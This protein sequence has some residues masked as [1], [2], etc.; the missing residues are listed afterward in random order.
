MSE[1]YLLVS[2][3][4]IYKQRHWFPVIN[5]TQSRNSQRALPQWRR[6][7]SEIWPASDTQWQHLRSGMIQ[8]P[9]SERI[10][11]VLNLTFHV[12]NLRILRCYR[13]LVPEKESKLEYMRNTQSFVFWRSQVR[14]SA[15]RQVILTFICLPK[16][17]RVNTVMVPQ[18][19]PRPHLPHFI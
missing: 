11:I 19:W 12:G 16:S 9:F 14:I 6:R 4:T 1:G 3:Y 7:V 15:H 8:L 10:E 13:H 5:T 2:L 17:L 18:I